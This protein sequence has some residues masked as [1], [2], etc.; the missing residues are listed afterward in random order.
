MYPYVML[1]NRFP[2]PN[3]L[4]IRK[5]NDVSYIKNFMG[6][7]NIIIDIPK[8]TKIPVLPCK[9]TKGRL[10]FATGK[11][12]GWWTHAEINRA[13][14]EGGVVLKVIKTYYY[15]KTCRPFKEFVNDM[16]EKRM[17]YKIA[18]SP[19]E[20]IVK[21]VLNSLF[22]KF[23]Q[24]FNARQNTIPTS[25]I[26]KE[27]IEVIDGKQRMHIKEIIGNFANVEQDTE[28]NSF[29]IPIWASYVTAYGRIKLYD[30]LKYHNPI[31]C[32]TDS[33]I[34]MDTLPTGNELGEL[35][36]EGNIVEGITVR[37]KMY[38]YKD[39]RGEEFSKIKGVSL[40]NII[41]NTSDMKGF[42]KI[43]NNPTVKYTKF[44]KFKESLKRK[45]MPNQIIEIEKEL[46][47][48]DS[49]RNW[50]GKTFDPEALQESEPWD[51]EDYNEI[52][53]TVGKRRVDSTRRNRLPTGNQE[54]LV[55]VETRA[56]HKIKG[57]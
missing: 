11:L 35:K 54:S 37:P 36:L 16:Y 41:L 57:I 26:R 19:M 40:R 48:E 30:L 51:M 38:S 10:I 4:R 28:P 20:V 43:L 13:I 18:K 49:K 25:A 31:Y 1:H 45:I 39:S 2:D 21:I 33:I 9:S 23:G 32:D 47:L 29:C 12:E 27:D 14:V 42:R 55:R 5:G 44:A 34:T 15:T 7:S 8:S 56:K 3:S 53:S 52:H 24:K 22:G 6:V 17:Q 50:L 46:S